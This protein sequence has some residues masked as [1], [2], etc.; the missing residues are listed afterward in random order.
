VCFECNQRAH[1]CA[2]GVNHGTAFAS[3]EY[4]ADTSGSSLSHEEKTPIAESVF[5]VLS[6]SSGTPSFSSSAITPCLSV[7][8]PP[9]SMEDTAVAADA[10]VAAMDVGIIAAAC[11]IKPGDSA[12]T[13]AAADSLPLDL[14]CRSFSFFSSFCFCSFSLRC[15]LSARSCSP[16]HPAHTM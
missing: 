7:G 11:C 16:S 9:P 12:S 14:S 8:T 1:T 2:E 6:S 4:T 13:A 10:A 3:A 15:S 5:C